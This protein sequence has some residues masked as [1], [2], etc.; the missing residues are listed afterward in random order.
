MWHKEL[1]HRFCVDNVKVVRFHELRQD[2][3]VSVQEAVHPHVVRVCRPQ[4]KSEER[5]AQFD[6]KHSKFG[7][8]NPQSLTC[9][10][11]SKQSAG[12]LG[13][14]VRFPGEELHDFAGEC[15]ERSY[16][17]DPGERRA[18]Q[19]EKIQ[20][21]YQL[22]EE[23]ALNTAKRR[24]QSSETNEEETVDDQSDTNVDWKIEDGDV[25]QLFKVIR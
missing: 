19:V 8:A 22:E 5:K 3:A 16:K 20:D 7:A 15:V 6:A 11:T 4:H 25:L 10:L 14:C 12:P 2:Y 9:S 23:E 13:K 21:D 24:S 17:L 18:Q 1:N